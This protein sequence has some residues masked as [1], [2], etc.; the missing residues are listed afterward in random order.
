MQNFHAIPGNHPLR[1]KLHNEVHAR[2]SSLISLPVR[3][4]YLALS[5]SSAEKAAENQYIA[6]LCDR[7]G[8]HRP[9]SDA[10]HFSAKFDNFQMSWEQ[11]GEF[12]SYTFYSSDTQ[13]G[14]F[15]DSAIKKVPADWLKGLK[16]QLLVAS[17]ACVVSAEEA[18]LQNT[19]DLS[20][21]SH[22]FDQNPIV[23]AHVS[24]GAASVFTDFKIHA[25]NFSRFL[26]INDHLRTAQAGRL[27]HRLFD[28]EAYR[29]LALMAFPQARQLYPELKRADHQLFTITNSMTQQSS[30]PAKLLDELT[31]LAAEVENLISSHHFRFAASSA[32][33]QLVGQ[34]LEDLRETRIQGI[35]TLGEFMRRRMEPA[36][37][38]CTAVSQRFAMISKRVNNASQLLRTKVDITIERQ[39][40]S[41][42]SSMALRAK[43]QLR[44]QQMVE[45]ISMV[46]ITYYAASLVGKISEALEATGLH[47]NPHLIEGAS[48]PFILIVFG[49]GRKRIHKIIASTRD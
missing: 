31:E 25:D 24:G 3:A 1:F 38:T 36:M 18:G 19:G 29:V 6:E 2:A 30:D 47:L 41:L 48:I 28:I 46:A 12:S 9:D 7:F 35:Q 34:R 17:H 10:D 43:M 15:F 23:G 21:L 26:I 32:Y 44:M 11:H 33:Y 27:L 5:L 39:N 20:P 14:A 37:H 8:A 16:G 13:T 40:Q 49:I 45:G 4:S 42:L 22:Y